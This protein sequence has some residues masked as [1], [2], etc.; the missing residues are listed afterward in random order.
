MADYL[1]RIRYII[2]PVIALIAI[3]NYKYVI[4]FN[5]ILLSLLV[6][7]MFTKQLEKMLEKWLKDENAYAIAL[8]IGVII[9]A[10]SA[11]KIPIIFFTY[12]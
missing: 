7:G 4:V 2:L 12:F 6:C 1:F 3:Y 9:F 10:L 8:L 5:I 11:Y